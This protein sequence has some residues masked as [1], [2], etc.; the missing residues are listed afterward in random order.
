[1]SSSILELFYKEKIPLIKENN[2]T[3]ITP[4]EDGLLV[5]NENNELLWVS[6]DNK[7]YT[8][9]SE[10][11]FHQTMIELPNEEKDAAIKQIMGLENEISFNYENYLL[12]SKKMNNNFEQ[13]IY[14]K[15]EEIGYGKIYKTKTGY[16]NIII[17]IKED[18]YA[19]N[20]YEFVIIF[21]NNKNKI[22]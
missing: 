21:E 8:T 17:D 4:R 16:R 3:I 12:V 14:Y 5:K 20:I 22:L 9:S 10:L 11:L 2:L 19:D 6:L 15:D 18:I 13:K 1:M 7:I